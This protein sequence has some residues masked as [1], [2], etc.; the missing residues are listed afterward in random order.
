MNLNVQDWKEFKIGKLF[1]LE[2]TKGIVT[3]DLE[4]GNDIPYIAAK[5]ECNGMMQMCKLD[6]FENWV[7]KGNCIVFVQLGAGAAGY[8]NYIESDFIGMNGKTSCGY[9]DDIMNKEIGLFLATILC[10]ER[11]KYSFGRSWTGDRLKDTII[12]L[13]IKYNDDG[14]PLIDSTKKYSDDGY[15]PNWEWMENYIKALHYK[16]IT[17]HNKVGN[18]QKLEVDGW[19][20][21]ALK[22]LFGDPIRGTRITTNDRMEGK[23]PF[24]TAGE[25]NEGVSDFISN[26]EAETHKNAITIDMFGNSFYHGYDFKCDDNI[27]VMTNSYI[28]EKIGNFIASVI[29][30]DIYKNSYGRQYRQKDYMR[31]IIKLPIKHNDDGTPFIDTTYQY[32]KDGYVPNW[33]WMENYIK[34]LPYGDRI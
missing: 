33:E 3:D 25:Q 26:S 8:A 11:P 1:R 21:F 2:P 23:I 5:Y 34:A 27:L 17:T 19:K 13:P 15:V 9:I 16:P 18:A 12:K 24:V 10:Q 22:D 6:G 30:I 31:H 14:T 4:I 32:S 7:S 28:N 20:E 29:S